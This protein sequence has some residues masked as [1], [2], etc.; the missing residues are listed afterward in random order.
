LTHAGQDSDARRTA[1]AMILVEDAKL[2]ANGNVSPQLLGASLI[3]KLHA[4][5]RP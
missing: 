1:M 5:L 2:R 3:A 4:T